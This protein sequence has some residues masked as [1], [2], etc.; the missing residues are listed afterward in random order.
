MWGA[1]LA[2][3][4]SQ[5]F[6]WRPQPAVRLTCHTVRAAAP[7]A[8]STHPGAQLVSRGSVAPLV[9]RR[10]QLEATAV[11][12]LQAL[13][14]GALLLRN[15][16]RK[17]RKGP[18]GRNQMKDLGST[19]GEGPHR[20]E[21]LRVPRAAC[22]ASAFSRRSSLQKRTCSVQTEK[23]RL[24]GSRDGLRSACLEDGLVAPVGSFR[25]RQRQARRGPQRRRL[26]PSRGGGAQRR[27]RRWCSPLRAAR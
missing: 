20:S 19:D 1:R 21:S 3:Q 23:P 18:E 4:P 26:W 7:A 11:A 17:E 27:R 22:V 14:G 24:G 2:E 10:R 15:R 5:R 16:K 8:P 13:L 12:Q 6:Q 25:Q 9:R